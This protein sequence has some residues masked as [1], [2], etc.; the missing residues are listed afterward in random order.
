MVKLDALSQKTQ[1]I[2]HLMYSVKKLSPGGHGIG[3]TGIV[4]KQKN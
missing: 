3:I 4:V 2:G 1:T